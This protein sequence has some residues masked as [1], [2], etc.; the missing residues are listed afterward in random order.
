MNIYPFSTFE[1]K[2]SSRW[3]NRGTL[4]LILI[5]ALLIAVGNLTHPAMA[6]GCSVDNGQAF[7]DAGQYGN[8]VQEFSCVIAADPAGVEGYRGRAE[9]SLLLGEFLNAMQNYARVMAVVLPE[10]QSAQTTIMA[11]YNARLSVD[12]ASVPALT[13]KSFAYWWFFSYG[14]AIQT[15]NTLLDIEPD[16]VYA[17]L[18][19]GSSRMLLGAAAAKGKL[20]LEKAIAL[21][22]T[23]PDVRFIVADAYTYGQPDPQRAFIEASF[24]LHGGLN[25]PRDHAI[26]AS[27]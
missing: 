7:I 18:F 9:A 26:L 2:T 5:L 24:A 1:A 8:A 12:P 17:N 10:D 23:S 20:D 14:Q 16:N 13:G 3:T 19:R 15:L 25:P 21:D 27:A 6:S 4:A 22:P 11:G